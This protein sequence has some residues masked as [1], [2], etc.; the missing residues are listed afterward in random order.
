MRDLSVAEVE[1]V[2]PTSEDAFV[3]LNSES[4]QVIA[5]C[6]PCAHEVGDQVAN[7][8]YADGVEELQS[9][10]LEDWPV[11]DRELASRERLDRTGAHSYSGCGRVISSDDGLVQVCG[12]I[13]DFGEVPSGAAFVEFV[14]TRLSL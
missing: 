5:F 12:F 14:V 1:R 4:G 2:D 9:P 13:L 11:E 7:L 8:V 3:T 6:F 10:Y